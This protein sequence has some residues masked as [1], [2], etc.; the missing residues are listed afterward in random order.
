MT[1][2]GAESERRA[3]HAGWAEVGAS[4][5]VATAAFS[6]R[7]FIP[8]NIGER[9][10]AILELL[11]VLVIIGAALIVA[12]RRWH[13]PEGMLSRAFLLIWGPYLALAMLIP[14]VGVVAGQFPLRGVAAI[15]VPITAVSAA[16]IGAATV[17]P[18]DPEHPFS[19][20]RRP[21]T[22]VVVV[23][24]LYSIFQ[25]LIV[26]NLVPPG[27][28]DRMAAWDLAVQRA[29]GRSLILGRS[30]GFFTNPNILGVWAGMVLLIGLLAVRGRWRYA[31]AGGGLA[32]LVLSQSRGPTLACIVALLLV[33][34]RA[35]RRHESP[36][37]RAVLTYA[38][39]VAAVLMGWLVL[40][41]AGA[42]VAGWLSRFGQGVQVVV[43]GDDPNVAGRIQFWVS[44]LALLRSH[45]FGTF[46]PP[47]LILGTPVDSE[48]VR[49]VLLG[50]AVLVISLAF[51]LFGSLLLLP[52][53]TMAK[54]AVWALSTL[55]IVSGVTEIPLQYP[56]AVLY[57][58]LVG[59]ALSASWHVSRTPTAPMGAEQS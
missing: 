58:A 37:L 9:Q 20:W 3:W 50:G 16:I 12:S 25:Q 35:V 23:V 15:R 29:Y 48:W 5:V 45:P 18:T 19:A 55:I 43:G 40:S 21:L 57:W 26:S 34:I 4:I 38:P 1:D 32:T 51:A 8:I 33:L 28:W 30:T 10:P 47:E 41:A 17:S 53:Q 44:G 24:L 27:P 14:L 7:I 56:P 31:V 39:I 42:P 52:R 36:P 49:T 59:A 46:G 6:Q 11:P 54:H 13:L 2:R 22:A